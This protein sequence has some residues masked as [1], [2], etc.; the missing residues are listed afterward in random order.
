MSKVQSIMFKK[1]YWDKQRARNW[2]LDHG[3]KTNKVDQA[4]S[5]FLRFRQEDPKQFK[6]FRTIKFKPS[7]YAVIGFP[8]KL[9]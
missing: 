3:F 7:V 6:D 4:G 8:D 2:L 1:R 5:N 9:E